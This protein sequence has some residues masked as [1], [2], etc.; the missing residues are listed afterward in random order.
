MIPELDHAARLIVLAGRCEPQ[1]EEARRL[2]VGGDIDWQRALWLAEKNYLIPLLAEMLATCAIS[3]LSLTLR[4]IL[5][6]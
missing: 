6:S 2:L 4:L 5:A 1:Q 3:A